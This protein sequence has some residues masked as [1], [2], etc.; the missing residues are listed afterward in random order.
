MT[1]SP[2]S[3]LY[4]RIMA[5]QVDERVDLHGLG[6][7]VESVRFDYNEDGY[8]WV[9]RKGNPLRYMQP[10]KSTWVVKTFKTLN[11]AKRNFLRMVNR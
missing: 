8:S 1:L 10:L 2:D 9:V 11:G 6:A 4:K 7:G 5:A 3:E